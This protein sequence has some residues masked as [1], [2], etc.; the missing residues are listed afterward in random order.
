VD[1]W[2]SAPTRREREFAGSL[3]HF[4][5]TVRTLTSTR[6]S[7]LIRASTG[8]GINPNFVHSMDGSAKTNKQGMCDK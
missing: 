8:S 3:R 5:S 4:A 1:R 6:L 7:Q 2:K